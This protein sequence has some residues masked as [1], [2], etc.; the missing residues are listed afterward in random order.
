MK[1]E[2]INLINNILRNSR[3]SDE[4]KKATLSLKLCDDNMFSISQ[5]GE[6]KQEVLVF[7]RNISSKVAMSIMAH[8]YASLRTSLSDIKRDAKKLKKLLQDDTHA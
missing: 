5:I 4:D 7:G 3:Y 6:D 1:N 2:P 8:A